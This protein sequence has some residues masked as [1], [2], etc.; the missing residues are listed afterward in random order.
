MPYRS[1]S[2]LYNLSTD[3]TGNIGPLLQFTVVL[4]TV[5]KTSFFCCSL[6]AAINGLC[7]C[8]CLAKGLHITILI[9]DCLTNL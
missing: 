5:H 6:R 2:S 1:F 3:R 9:A 4:R 8:R 7:L